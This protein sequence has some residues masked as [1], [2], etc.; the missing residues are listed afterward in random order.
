MQVPKSHKPKSHKEKI[1]FKCILTA[2]LSIE[3]N[4][5]HIELLKAKKIF[6]YFMSRN[7][8]NFAYIQNKPLTLV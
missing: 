8:K 2:Q 7:R 3:L 1:A 5:Y 4:R 6:R